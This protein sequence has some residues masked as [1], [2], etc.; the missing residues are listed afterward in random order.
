MASGSEKYAKHNKKVAKAKQLKSYNK[1]TRRS[2]NKGR[3]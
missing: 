1:V 3:G 2:K